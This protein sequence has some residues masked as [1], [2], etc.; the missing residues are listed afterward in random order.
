MRIAAGSEPA[1]GSVSA[2]APIHSPVAMRG[3]YF[4]FCSGVA[5]RDDAGRADPGV[6]ADH[7]RKTVIG[8]AHLFFDGAFAR[9]VE[10]D[11]AVLLGDRQ[12]EK[13]ELARFLQEIL[14]D[15]VVLFDP[16]RA[17]IDLVADEAADFVAELSDFS[18]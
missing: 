10:A 16:A 1:C 8:L 15:L 3:R 7:G 5:E 12:A 9:E 4:C 13:A 2:N 11:A 6:V 18:R 14:G 17:R